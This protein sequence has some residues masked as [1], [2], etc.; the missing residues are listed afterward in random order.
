MGGAG[1]HPFRLIAFRHADPP[2]TFL[3]AIMGAD[4]PTDDA[5]SHRFRSR[6]NPEGKPPTTRKVHTCVQ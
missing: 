1:R 5:F 6:G 4:R 3:H 2:E